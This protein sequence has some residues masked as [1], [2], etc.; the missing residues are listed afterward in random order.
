MPPSG[1][2]Q[3][4]L[5]ANLAALARHETAARAV[6]GVEPYGDD[7][8]AVAKNGDPVVTLDGRLL[9]SRYDPREEA[10]RQLG[11]HVDPL[12][13]FV[14]LGS[15]L[16]YTALELLPRLTGENRL[17]WVEQDARL[18]RT[19]LERV[20]VTEV[21]AHPGCHVLV[22]PAAEA[23]YWTLYP[24]ILG[25]LSGPVRLIMHPPSRQRFPSEFEA[26]RRSI[27]E[28]SAHGAVLL[29]TRLL[30][31]KK[32]L[33]NQLANLREYI[34]SPGIAA[35]ENALA[36]E[37]AIV[38]SAG[39]S[40][41]RN[42]HELKRAEGRAAI[43]AVSTAL[44][45]LMAAGITPDFT[46]LIDH[47]RISRRYFEGF[48]AASAPPMLCDL[49]ATPEGVAAYPGKKIFFDDLLI[50]TLLDGA[51]GEKG[52]LPA[53]STVAHT[54]FH[55]AKYL[56]AD[57]IVLV[58]QDLSYPGNL[59]HVPGTAVQAQEYPTTHRFHTFETRELQYYFRH[60]SRFIKVPAIPEGDVPTCDIFFTYLKEFEKIF[61]AHDGTVIDATEGG[62]RIV[63]TEVATLAQTLERFASGSQRDVRERLDGAAT[64]TGETRID[65][66]DAVLERRDGELEELMSSYESMT[67]L[68]SRVIDKAA[69]GEA[70]DE[71]V[72]KVQR[73]NET[74]QSHGRLYHVLSQLSQADVWLR[75]REDRRLDGEEATGVERQHRQA[76]RDRNYVKALRAAAEFLRDR[77][78]EARVAMRDAVGA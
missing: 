63:G 48:D 60:R 40:L 7:A 22:A 56:G 65:A 66:C 5:R 77:L 64:R 2:R 57:P 67:G 3:E 78:R 37:P 36:G 38:V 29:R 73:L 41:K 16:G 69:D 43:I 17:Y 4:L 75:V 25:I 68:L 55:W 31:S 62:A 18:F 13:T 71:L 33:G 14:L 53:G 50:N 61:A 19:L 59:L 28:L 49:K 9:H 76:L 6:E 21:L 12:A 30:L 39:P 35:F 26:H 52:Q 1:E 42:I 51:A 11:D 54:A 34:E 70:A 58:G 15:G 27:R 44:R 20:D 23:L 74:T 45:P 24:D 10:R 8:V 72:L 46:V 32:A 47:H